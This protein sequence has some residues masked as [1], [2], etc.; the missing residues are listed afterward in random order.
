MKTFCLESSLQEKSNK[1]SK[2]SQRN[3]KTMSTHFHDKYALCKALNW[4]ITETKEQILVGLSN[5]HM[6]F[7]WNFIEDQKV[8]VLGYN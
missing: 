3:E 2:K 1:M 5:R 6:K 4:S 7:E 8:M